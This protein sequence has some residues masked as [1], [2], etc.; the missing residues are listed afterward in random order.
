MLKATKTRTAW[1]PLFIVTDTEIAN[2]IH[3]TQGKDEKHRLSR[4]NKKSEI[5]TDTEIETDRYVRQ[6][7][8]S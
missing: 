2:N 3:T 6:Q 1:L 4:G 7:K 8:D 5:E